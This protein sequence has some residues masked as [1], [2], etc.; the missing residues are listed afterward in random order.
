MLGNGKD[1]E[2]CGMTLESEAGYKRHKDKFC[3]NSKYAD[4]NTLNQ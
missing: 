2:N 1:C 3:I 4:I